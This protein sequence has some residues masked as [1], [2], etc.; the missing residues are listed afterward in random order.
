MKAA[1]KLSKSGATK[2]FEVA[3]FVPYPGTDL[4]NRRDE[5]GIKI[6][7]WDF[8]RWGRWFGHEPVFEYEHFLRNEISAA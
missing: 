8:E 7:D 6:L 1:V 2:L 3:T 5:L 4:Y